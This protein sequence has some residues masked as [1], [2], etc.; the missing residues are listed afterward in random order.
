[1]RVNALREK[2]LS[3]KEFRKGRLE[4]ALGK[5]N[6]DSSYD[7]AP[8]LWPPDVKSQFIGKDPDAGKN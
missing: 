8:I 5:L 3:T 4:K 1:M 2:K 6:F 7:T